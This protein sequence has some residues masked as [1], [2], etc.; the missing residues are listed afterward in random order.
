MAAHRRILIDF[1]EAKK[2]VKVVR[3]SAKRETNLPLYILCQLRILL[4]II[5]LLIC[6]LFCFLICICLFYCIHFQL[7]L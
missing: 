1:D 4:A 7:Y 2:T 3:H 6:A 5:D